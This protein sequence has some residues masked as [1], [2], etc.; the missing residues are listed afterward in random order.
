MSRSNVRQEFERLHVN[1]GEVKQEEEEND[2]QDT[3]NKPTSREAA[4]QYEL[5][6]VRNINQ[7]IEGVL[8]SL[9][10][11]KSNMSTVNQTVDSASTLLNT[12]TRILAQTEQNQ[13]LILDPNWHGAS[14]DIAAEEAE[15]IQRKQEAERRLREE[16]ERREALAR[17]AE[18]ERRK[19]EAAAASKSTRGTTL[20]GRTR[21]GSR[22]PST[23][24]STTGRRA[25]TT[26]TTASSSSGVSGT[27]SRG[28]SS[29]ATR[30]T[31]GLRRP[32][33]SSTGRAVSGVSRGTTRG[34]S[35]TRGT[36]S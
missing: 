33:F 3:S 25:P 15:E 6:T 32:G 9:H 36:S 7:V 29:S 27:S 34:T 10:R 21:I 16:Q 12:W 1:D 8:S 23:Y 13:R 26:T 28:V 18:E 14:E 17:K 2:H 11:A 5:E 31:T 24:S 20:R 4:L 22:I 30:G 19:T 35:R